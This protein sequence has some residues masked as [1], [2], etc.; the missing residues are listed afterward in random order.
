MVLMIERGV[1]LRLHRSSAY[2]VALK[3]KIAIEQVGATYY[4]RMQRGKDPGLYCL[5]FLYNSSAYLVVLVYRTQMLT[6][7]STGS[8]VFPPFS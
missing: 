2:L 3:G 6:A 7:K 4:G 5:I 8:D 1:V